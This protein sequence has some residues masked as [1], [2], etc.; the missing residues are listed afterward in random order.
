MQVIATSPCGGGTTAELWTS[1]LQ[2]RITPQSIQRPAEAIAKWLIKT[3][4]IYRASWY[5][6][7]WPH[8]LKS[9]TS[10]D[11][12]SSQLIHVQLSNP[13]NMGVSIVTMR[14]LHHEVCYFFPITSSLLSERVDFHAGY[15]DHIRRLM[16]AKL[17]T[18]DFILYCTE[19]VAWHSG[20][21][22]VSD[23][24]TFPVLRSTC[25]WWVTTNV[26]KPSATGQPNRPIQPFILSGSINK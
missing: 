22:F 24:P 1:R 16:A 8:T 19:L 3:R 17:P 11:Q 7:A 18:L 4:A 13:S 15:V 9:V 12:R 10:Q 5:H 14:S 25:S 21:T 26:G 20:S 2:R 23:W 6:E